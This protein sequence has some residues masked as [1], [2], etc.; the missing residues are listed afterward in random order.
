MTQVAS[1][2]WEVLLDGADRERA[3]RI[4]DEIA[5]AVATA[6]PKLQ[7]GLM[8]PAGIAVFLAHAESAG[9][10]ENLGA[11]AALEAGLHGLGATESVGLWTGYAGLRWALRA[12]S[13]GDDV[14]AL[15][16]HIDRTI[17][18]SLAR[19]G[20]AVDSDLYSGLAGVILGYLDD[21]SP[22]ARH[23]ISCALDHLEA[24][25]VTSIGPN[26]V[27]C[28]HGLAGVIAALA[29][30]IGTDVEPARSRKLLVEHLD[31]LIRY[32]ATDASFSWC[33]GEPGIALA[34]LAAASVLDRPDL[35]SR[36]VSLALAPFRRASL[37]PPVDAGLCHG[38]AGIAHIYNRLYQATRHPELRE[39]A[40]EW[41]HKTMDLHMPGDGIGG[42][43]MLRGKPIT[44]W[45]ADPGLLAGSSGVGMV[46]L[47]GATP[48]TPN[49]DRLIAADLAPAHG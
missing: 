7:A 10:A 4:V 49:W 42:Y 15:V 1:Q 23:V 2:D 13:A 33:K 3:L 32:D 5:R 24:F 43:K 26:S 46:L 6:V 45:E 16:D 30:C 28:V 44:Y 38:T 34:L 37:A 31:V 20:Q 35:A 41:L 29:R 9:I 21:D 36:A 40:R 18:K 22:T 47:A 27:G 48:F 17:A 14:D 19:E 11:A 39:H 8:G 25:S 12:L